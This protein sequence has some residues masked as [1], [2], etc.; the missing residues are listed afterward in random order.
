MEKASTQKHTQQAHIHTADK[1]QTDDLCTQQQKNW[2][3][4]ERCILHVHYWFI[5]SLADPDKQRT[6]Y[7]DNRLCNLYPMGTTMRRVRHETTEESVQTNTLSI[8]YEVIQKK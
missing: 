5:R 3:S 1:T 6:P 2:T 7:Y 4:E 8:T